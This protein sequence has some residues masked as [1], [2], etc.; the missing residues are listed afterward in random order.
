MLFR[1]I[2]PVGK[3][4]LAAV[5]RYLE[6]GRPGLLKQ[7][8]SPCLFVTA[9]GGPLTR[10]AF[11]KLLGNYGRK[12]GIFKGLTPHAIRHSFATHLLERGADLRSVQTMLGHADISTTQI[13]THVMRSKLRRTL[14]E[15]H[16]RA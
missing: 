12:A 3:E 10:Q 1:S 16:S 6:T 11:W 2:V 4:A 13:Y 14:D 5:R 9:R 7:R 15:H 8:G